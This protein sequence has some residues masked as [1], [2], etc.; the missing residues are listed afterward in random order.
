MR[1][2]L[3]MRT[4]PLWLGGGK[5]IRTLVRLLSNGFQEVGVPSLPVPVNLQNPLKFPGFSHFIGHLP[6]KCEIIARK[7][8]GKQCPKVIGS[9]HTHPAN[10]FRFLSAKQKGRHKNDERRKDN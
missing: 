4:K 10:V 7:V 6:E 8:R 3:F 1:L 2:C 5:G 9:A